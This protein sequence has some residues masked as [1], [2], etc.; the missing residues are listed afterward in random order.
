V[1]E[2]APDPSTTPTPVLAPVTAVTAIDQPVATAVTGLPAGA[3]RYRVTLTGVLV[4]VPTKDT[5]DNTDG[6]GD[7]IAAAAIAM[8][9]EREIDAPQ[10]GRF[11][12]NAAL[13]SI[14]AVRGVE[15]GDINALRKEAD[16]VRAGHATTNGGGLRAQDIAPDGFSLG[17]S[18]GTPDARKF[19]LLVW[20]GILHQATDAV[21]IVPSV[22]ERDIARARLDAYVDGW[23]TGSKQDTLRVADLQTR[24]PGIAISQT[25][26]NPAAPTAYSVVDLAGQLL[27]RPLGL[28]VQPLVVEYH[29]RF[30][31]LTREKLADLAAG[32][33][34]SL[35]IQYAEPADNPVLGGDYTLEMRIERL[36]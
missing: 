10:A 15:Y 13:G 30:I 34:Q 22:W 24:L 19:P 28:T 2:R 33:Y 5:L 16:R 35:A 6:Q 25:T 1:T 18:R 3:G 8:Y 4:T 26:V 21:L 11:G 7:E 20:E 14:S 23:L 9:F 31:V 12:T 27:D 32:S 36:E 29:D 17:N